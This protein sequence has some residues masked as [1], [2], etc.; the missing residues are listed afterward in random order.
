VVPATAASWKLNKLFVQK[1]VGVA[2]PLCSCSIFFFRCDAHDFAYY[3][4]IILYWMI[5][6][7]IMRDVIIIAFLF[8]SRSLLP[9]SAA[10]AMH[11]FWRDTEHPAP[12]NNRIRMLLMTCFF[13]FIWAAPANFKWFVEIRCLFRSQTASLAFMA[14]CAVLVF[15]FHSHALPASRQTE[16]I[17]EVQQSKL[18]SV[19]LSTSEASAASSSS[20]TTTLPAILP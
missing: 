20:S 4:V 15:S 19:C 13:I 2:Y 1:L 12:A 9:S 18:N 6:M 14:R 3:C 16:W 10:F 17:D 8:V 7:I 5:F 11:G